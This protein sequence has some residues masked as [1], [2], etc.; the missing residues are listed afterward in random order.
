VRTRLIGVLAA[1]AMLLGAATA[2]VPAASA[3]P[4]V[5]CQLVSS[6]VV[7]SSGGRSYDYAVTV[8]MANYTSTSTKITTTLLGRLGRTYAISA[9]V[10][11]NATVTKTSEFSAPR[12]T[13]FSVSACTRG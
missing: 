9:T 12:G 6:K 13:K 5:S 8:R 2:S 1:G 3:S 11:G 10:S 4:S 7:G